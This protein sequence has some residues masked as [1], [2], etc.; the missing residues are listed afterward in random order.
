MPFSIRAV[1]PT[2]DGT[3]LAIATVMV[4]SRWSDVHWRN[5]FQ[6]GTTETEAIHANAARVPWNLISGRA[7]KREQIAVNEITGEIVAYCRWVLPDSLIADAAKGEAVVWPE[8]QVKDV[9]EEQKPE[10]EKKRKS[11]LD[12]HGRLLY[13]R[14]DMMNDR[15]TPLEQEDAQIRDEHEEMLGELRTTSQYYE[16]SF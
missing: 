14:H 8:A 7:A 1:D 12:E 10:F 5:L 16:Q 9:T 4:T 3:P 13:L 6:P 11:A 15:S 2:V